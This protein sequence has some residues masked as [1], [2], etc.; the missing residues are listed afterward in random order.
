MAF[1]ALA[2]ALIYHEK[3]F[4][5]GDQYHRKRVLLPWLHCRLI[6][7]GIVETGNLKRKLRVGHP[8]LPL[9]L[10]AYID[11]RSIHMPILLA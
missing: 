10:N 8:Q 4:K 7:S 6:V 5:A 3:G 2:F 9:N 1:Y 11:Y